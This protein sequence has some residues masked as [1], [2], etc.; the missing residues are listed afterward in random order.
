[1]KCETLST[2][3]TRSEVLLRLIPWAIV[4]IIVVAGGIRI[5][6]T[7]SL[8][9]RGEDLFHQNHVLLK[10]NSDMLKRIE[11]ILQDSSEQSLSV[12]RD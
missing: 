3:M 10:E 4:I 7:S 8:V 6:A 12:R 11:A 1:M 2:K 5:Q 9:E